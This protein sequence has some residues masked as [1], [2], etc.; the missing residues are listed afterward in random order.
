VS[1]CVNVSVCEL[2]VSERECER[3]CECA[4]FA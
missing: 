3:E 4:V 2:Y 1:V